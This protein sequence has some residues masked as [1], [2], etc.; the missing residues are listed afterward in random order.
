[1]IIKSLDE[2]RT[3]A[4]KS[5]EWIKNYL[6]PSILVDNN[7]LHELKDFIESNYNNNIVY[8]YKI[9]DFGC[10][11]YLP[12]LNLGIKLISYIKYNETVVDKKYQLNTYLKFEENGIHLIQIF[13][14][15]WI[16]KKEIVKSRLKNL[17]GDSKT[18]YARNC[19]IRELK[20]NVE[21]KLC[22]DFINNNHTQGNI[23]S[24]IKFGLFYNDELVSVMTFGKLRKN[25]GQKGG[26]NDYELLRY[27][28]KCNYSVVG[29]ASKL[30]KHFIKEYDPLNITSYADKMW[31]FS[32]NLYVKIGMTFIHRSEPSYFYIVG[33]VRKNRFGYRKD[34]LL[35]CGYDGN[36][37][38][39][40]DICYNNGLYRIF[41]TGTEKMM[42]IKK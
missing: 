19:V 14:D 18:I 6:K 13:E 23:G 27:C 36:H 24:K 12:K 22:S 31:S 35:T 15:I 29:G 38:G 25:L 26:P 5:D 41:D 34:V 4:T 7:L 40:H 30:F 42:Y 32:D 1:M 10:D 21:Q 20:S 37:W 9:E 11:F 8:D 39:E 16:N 3:I 28:N 33:D 17:F 2:N